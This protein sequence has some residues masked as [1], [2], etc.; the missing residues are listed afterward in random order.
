MEEMKDGNLYL[1]V[2]QSL[3]RQLMQLR[4]Q[5]LKGLMGTNP[6]FNR[7]KAIEQVIS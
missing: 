3:L 1:V 6:L 4:S 7:F 5:A 2:L